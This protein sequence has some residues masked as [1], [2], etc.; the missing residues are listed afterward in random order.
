MAEKIVAVKG[1]ND[2]LPP[3]SA[4]WEWFEDTVRALMRRYAYQN[5]R[6]PIVEH[7]PLFVRGLGEVT[8]IVEKEMYSFVDSMNGDPLSLRPEGTAGVVRAV[9][10]H[11]ALYDGGKRLFYIGPMFRHER[12]Q[13]GRYRQFHQVGVEALGFGGPDV[14]A[15]VILMCR[16]LWKDL[17][18][19]EVRLD[20]NSLGQPE[21]R[22]AHRAALI[23]HFERHA[24]L[25]DEDARRRLHSNPLRIL[26]TK[27]PAM[28]AMV[29][30]A[31]QLIDYLGEASLKHFDA[32]K[33]M[34]DAAGQPYRVNP[35]LVRGMDYYN[36]TVF[37]WVTDKLG[38]QGTICGG[39][40]YDGLV[41]LVG[42]KPAP[43]I[44]W[45]MGIERVLDLVQ[46]LG[47]A[48][49]APVPDAY[50]IVPDGAALPQAMR[51]VEALRAAGVA[52]QLHVGGGSMKS[53]FKKADASGARHAL[54]FGGDELARGE[55]AVKPLR[56]AAA[57]Q[58]A[59]PIADPAIWASELLPA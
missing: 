8:D 9:V 44:G 34:L 28:Q 59:R 35:R 36:L 37:E 22:K 27:N 4:R 15:E 26:D 14:D 30:A 18:L 2:I 38:A 42:G 25:L 45:G 7:T 21:E 29:E 41:E 1:M 10:E 43:G 48:P 39:G 13:R 52:V 33:A 24:E 16:A 32:L 19:G 12:P 5:V 55:V 54:I 23:A 46:Q 3:E 47:V 53:Q 51:V 58:T 11:S 31:P 40:R 49:P 17:G 50:A 6:T 20:I 56:D 57:A